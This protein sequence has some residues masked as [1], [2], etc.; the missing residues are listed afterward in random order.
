MVVLYDQQI[1]MINII[2]K[3]T[4]FLNALDHIPRQMEQYK[5]EN[6]KLKKYLPTLREVVDG[7]WKKEEE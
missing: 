4:V 2:A 6:A 5:T 1:V 3:A 7:M